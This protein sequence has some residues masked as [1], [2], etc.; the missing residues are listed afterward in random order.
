MTGLKL[1]LA[2]PRT[3]RGLVFGLLA[4]V[5]V[6]FLRVPLGVAM[7]VLIPCALVSEWWAGR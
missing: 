5:S 3:V 6:G 1:A 4:L 2:L 7:L